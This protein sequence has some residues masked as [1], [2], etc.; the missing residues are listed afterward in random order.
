MALHR[1]LHVARN[2]QIRKL[3]IQM[4]NQACVQI[5]KGEEEASGECAHLIQQCRNLL[6]SPDWKI[7]ITHVYREGNR[8]ADWLANQGVTQSCSLH[9]FNNPPSPLSRILAE[10][11]QGVAFP[12]LIPP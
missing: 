1:G 2:L 10:D 8:A 7:S 6:S 5:F 4:D 12:R 11:L 3:I 9:L